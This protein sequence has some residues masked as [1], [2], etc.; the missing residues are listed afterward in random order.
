MSKSHRVKRTMISNLL[1]CQG[2]WGQNVYLGTWSFQEER[3]I[4]ACL[5]KKVHLVIQCFDKMVRKENEML[6]WN[7]V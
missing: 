1:R 7:V 6:L 5:L 4:R 2:T 3:T